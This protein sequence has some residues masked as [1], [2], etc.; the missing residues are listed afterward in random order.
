MQI[1]PNRLNAP[2]RSRVV[3]GVRSLAGV[4]IPAA[5]GGLPALA[6]AFFASAA[7]AQGFFE[8]TYLLDIRQGTVRSAAVRAASR[9]GFE[10]SDGSV[11]SFRDWY[12]SQWIDLQVDFLTRLSD[13]FGFIWG[14]TTGESGE[15]YHIT[16][17]FRIG[18]AYSASISETSNLS[19]SVSTTL[20][21]ILTER[22][23]TADYGDIGGVR[24]VN[25]RLAASAL[26][27]EETLRYRMRMNGLDD[28]RVA[29]QY[30]FRF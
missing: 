18:F 28:T 3:A 8:S 12:S 17:G 20:G 19:L 16:P 22:A 5:C 26:P 23:C 9:G 4:G 7:A 14:L 1:K 29:V 21:S 6:V 25:C 10:L 11:V 15:K 24:R 30:E 27:P 2:A 13:D